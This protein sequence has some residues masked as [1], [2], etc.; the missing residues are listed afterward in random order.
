MRW[1]ACR[2]VAVDKRMD[3]L[4]ALKRTRRTPLLLLIGAAVTFIVTLCLPANVWVSGVKAVA[5]A[6]MV[7]ALA[8]WFAVSALFRRVPV[9]L[10]ARHT[11]IIP[12]NKD[13][14]ADNLA[15]F[16]QEQ[17]L[18][19]DSLLAL[20]RRHSPAQIV[21]RWL[22]APDNA[23]KLGSHIMQVMRG[24]LDVTDDAR[25]QRLIRKAV[26]RAIDSVDFT[27]TGAV[28]LEGMVRDQRHQVLLDSA[29]AR[30]MRMLDK[31][32]TRQFIAGQV[33]QWFR[34]E[35]PRSGKLLPR[36]W[37]GEQSAEAVTKALTVLLGEISRDE[38]HALR[39]SFNRA[40]A[41]FI[42]RLKTDPQMAARAENI[43]T[44]LKQD[45]AL[46]GYVGELWRDLRGWLKQ[47]LSSDNSLTHKKITAAGEWL[48]QSLNRDSA[49]RD[50]LNTHLEQAVKTLAPDFSAFMASHISDTI[51]SWD[52]AEMAHQIELNIG[53]DLQY[54]R[55]N[56]T[57]VGGAIGLA[58]Y[59]LSLFSGWL[60][61]WIFSLAGG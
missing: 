52:A 18:N 49:L 61:P 10:I 43:K 8:D 39:R 11:A 40:V 19:T 36:A 41:H 34:R 30:L 22:S 44:W 17:F 58:L 24:F 57:L 48:G 50:S 9:P 54:I 12:R 60:G 53:K 4:E 23:A 42:G 27:Q 5:E 26:N 55:I 2:A 7:G 56:G 3:K 37:I 25:I 32:A 35:Y 47:D 15:A 14:I 28:I 16:V 29:I 6:A 21:A 51:K 1:V 46:N 20:I 31:P 59:L 45:A 33:V 13:R 38:N